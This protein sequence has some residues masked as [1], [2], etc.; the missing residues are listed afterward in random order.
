MKLYST[1]KVLQGRVVDDSVSVDVESM[2][3]LLCFGI[4]EIVY[5]QINTHYTLT[6]VPAAPT[7]FSGILS[8]VF[9]YII[10]RVCLYFLGEITPMEQLQLVE[11]N[12]T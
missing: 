7:T 5:T 6:T 8:Y 10:S 4:D 9:Y 3:L 11:F 12:Q 1:F 2:A